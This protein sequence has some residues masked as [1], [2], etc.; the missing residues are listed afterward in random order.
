MGAL[1]DRCLGPW[2]PVEA[3][4][5]L[6]V[7]PQDVH[8]GAVDRAPEGAARGAPLGVRQPA[9]GGVES[10]V[11]LAVVGRHRAA[12]G[13]SDHGVRS[14]RFA[15]CSIPAR[16]ANLAFSYRLNKADLTAAGARSG[17]PESNGGSGS[18]SMPSWIVR[19]AVSPAISAATLRPKSMPEVTPPAVIKLP[20]FTILDFSYVA[21][22]RGKRSV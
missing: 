13:G 17:W 20:S 6:T 8:E 21:P 3:R 12:V 4:H 18:Y 19:A 22:K 2:P 1:L 7:A 9:R 10:A 14:L 11:H 15:V 16:R 5:P